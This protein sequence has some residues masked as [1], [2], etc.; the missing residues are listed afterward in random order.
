MPPK[1][2]RVPTGLLAELGGAGGGS[3]IKQRQQGPRMRR[4][5][6]IITAGTEGSLRSRGGVDDRK[7]G[8]RDASLANS[9][10]R[11]MAVLGGQ[12]VQH[13]KADSAVTGRG[14]GPGKLDSAEYENEGTADGDRPQ[15]RES[16]WVQ[17][18]YSAQ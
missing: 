12:R 1:T 8:L 16:R 14:S 11:G 13:H 10:I 17:L 9:T 5:D 4:F 15:H 2:R 18:S 3:T 7:A 6:V